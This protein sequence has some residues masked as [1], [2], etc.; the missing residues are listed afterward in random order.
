MKLPLEYAILGA[1]MRGPMHGYEIYKFLSSGLRGVWSV[2]MSNMYGILKKLESEAHVHG[3]IESDG[4]RPAKRVFVITEKG[5]ECFSEWISTPVRNIRDMRV[6]F[7]AK[8][9]FLKTLGRSGGEEL[10]SKQ[11]AQC[12]KMLESMNRSTTKRSEFARLLHDF[13]TCQ[14]RSMLLWLETCRDFLKNT[15]GHGEA[16]TRKRT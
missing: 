16:K 12:Q 3:T 4:N 10:V 2:G 15:E 1:L 5:R 9:Y 8:V 13:R 11:M 14:I 7:M 6:E